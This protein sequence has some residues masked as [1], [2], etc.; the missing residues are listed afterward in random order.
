MADVLIL[1][2]AFG[3]AAGAIYTGKTRLVHS[4]LGVAVL[5][6]LVAMVVGIA[7]EAVVSGG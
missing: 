6:T 5:V 7:V 1:M 3:A 2:A 4:R